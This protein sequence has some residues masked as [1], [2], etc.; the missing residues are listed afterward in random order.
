[1]PRSWHR[2][3]RLAD[4]PRRRMNLAEV[5]GHSLVVVR[6]RSDVHV[7]RNHC[8]HQGA[9]ICGGSVSGT[10][11]PS[12]PDQ[13][14]YG[15]VDQIVRCP[16]HGWEFNVRSGEAVF[17]ISNKKLVLYPTEVRG[18]ELWVFLAVR[19]AVREPVS[20]TA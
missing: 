19:D 8:P 16:W 1:M 12:R 10:Y 15:M 5:A 2:V 11:L 18:S 13:L 3:G 14:R 6:S 4:F 7:F 20:Q 9:P 17:G